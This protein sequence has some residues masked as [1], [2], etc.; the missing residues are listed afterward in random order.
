MDTST[1][2]EYT[3]AAELVFRNVYIDFLKTRGKDTLMV[4][5]NGKSRR[6]LRADARS[7]IIATKQDEPIQFIKSNPKVINNDLRELRDPY[8]ILGY[9]KKSSVQELVEKHISQY[10]LTGSFAYSCSCGAGKTVA[11]IRIMQSLKVKTMIISSRN[12]VND[13]WKA[14][15]EKLYPELI[16]ETIEGKFVGGMKLRNF[17]DLDMPDTDVWIYSP[18]Y[19]GPKV[20]TLNILPSLIIYDE[21]HSLLSE[22]FIRVLLYSLTKV[23]SGQ[24]PELPVMIALSATFPNVGTKAYKSIEKIFGKPFRTPSEIT[25]IPVRVWDYYDHTKRP[26]GFLDRNYHGLDNIE[27]IDYFLNKVDANDI[28]DIHIDPRSTEYKGIIMS[29]SIDSSAYAALAV[30]QRWN[31]N[32]L[33]IRAVN[34]PSLFIPKDKYLTYAYDYAVSFADLLK[35]NIGETVENIH[36]KIPLT[37]IIVGTVHR[38]REGFSVQNITWGICTKFVWNQISRV[39]ILGRI[40]RNSDDPALNSHPRIMFCNCGAQPSNLKVPHAKKPLK[41]LYD[42]DAEKEVFEY[43]GYHRI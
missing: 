17:K 21:V 2:T 7:T 41:F 34:E 14:T 27:A 8:D 42:M 9:T 36:E 3:A 23:M 35:D 38:L 11:G 31:I 15:L 12:A 16:I 43:E 13:Q 6:M 33:L 37:S 19:L 28:N 1:D 4:N 40:R 25:S 39:Q 10:P 32:V 5:I 26:H 29:Y 30:H 22:K 20:N 24:T 18:Q